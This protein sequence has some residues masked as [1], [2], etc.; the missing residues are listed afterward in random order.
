MTYY[1]FYSFKMNIEQIESL[2][3]YNLHITHV[4]TLYYL[5]VCID[6]SIFNKAVSKCV[7]KTHTSTVITKNNKRYCF[8]VY[9]NGKLII[10]RETDP[11]KIIALID[12]FLKEFDIY[13][14]NLDV[15]SISIEGIRCEGTLIY[16]I[17]TKLLCANQTVKSINNG[18]IYYTND[19]SLYLGPHAIIINSSSYDDIM[20][21]CKHVYINYMSVLVALNN[22]DNSFFSMIP[23][24]VIG[25]LLNI[26]IQL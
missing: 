17:P 15:N 25:C 3:T 6:L 8:D 7:Y 21:I 20:H 22:M 4:T 11:I 2:K 16:D 5:N 1:L 12:I 24:D 23:N 9:P 18:R 13:C 26:L 10:H 19:S 14:D